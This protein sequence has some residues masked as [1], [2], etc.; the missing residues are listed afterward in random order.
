MRSWR[1]RRRTLTSL[2]LF[3]SLF[4][5]G[6]MAAP[7]LL[8]IGRDCS[9]RTADSGDSVLVVS[10]LL[11]LKH[12]KGSDLSLAR[13]ENALRSWLNTKSDSL[14]VRVLALV[15]QSEHCS[16]SFTS[17]GDVICT[18]ASCQHPTYSLPTISCIMATAAQHARPNEFMMFLNSDVI[19]ASGLSSTLAELRKRFGHDFVMVGRRHDVDDGQKPRRLDVS[20]AL[21]LVQK[22]EESPHS[23]F[24]IDYF[25]FDVK[26]LPNNFPD[27]LIGRWRWDNALLLEFLGKESVTVVDA[28]ESVLAV[29][30]GL[31]RKE[32]DQHKR[33]FGADYNDD[34]VKR[35]YAEAYL[36]GRIDNAPIVVRGVC[37]DCRIQFQKQND[38]LKVLAYRRAHPKTRLLLM[39]TVTAGYANLALNWACW[40]KTSGFDNY[41]FLA[42]DENSL[43]ILRSAGQPTAFVGNQTTL[44]SG[45][46]DYG[47]LQFQIVMTYRTEV[48]QQLLQ[49]GLTVGTADVDIIWT[50]SVPELFNTSCDVIGMPHKKTKMTGG[51]VVVRH[52]E[53]AVTYWTRVLYCQ[54]QNMAFL[55]AHVG[56]RYEAS[57]Y[58]EQE[59][60]NDLRVKF[61]QLNF[62]LLPE[63]LFVDGEAYFTD[64]RP[65][66]TGVVPWAIHNNWIVGIGNKTSRFKDNGLMLWDSEKQSCLRGPEH[67]SLPASIR[68]K[69]TLRIRVLTQSRLSSL[70]RL[71]QSLLDADFGDLKVSLDVSVDAA[72]RADIEQLRARNAT[73]AFLKSFVWKLGSYQ[74]IDQKAHKGIVQQWLSIPAA[75]HE[76]LLILEDDIV[77]SK[78]AFKFITSAVEHFY[79]NDS[80]YDPSLFGIML[81]RQHTILGE[82]KQVRYGRKPAELLPAG[83]VF[84]RYQLVS[85]WA[86]VMIGSVWNSFLSWLD[87]KLTSNVTFIPCVPTLLSNKW[88]LER[89]G[90]LWTPYFIRFAYEMGLYGLYTNHPKGL[91]LITNF[92][93]KGVNFNATNPVDIDSLVTEEADLRVLVKN[94]PP[95][96]DVPLF[97]FHFRLVDVSLALARRSIYMENGIDGC[98]WIGRK[99]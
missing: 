67:P 68:E 58:T 25:L 19:I 11:G 59:C 12:D 88:T 35:R 91:A 56:K 8:G 32:D 40:A 94:T 92:R 48:V 83:T 15:E 34:V 5:M 29:H 1:F 96:N 33:R 95:M 89:P 22:T 66:L 72:D 71:L 50:N 97:D 39:L 55:R 18:V 93:E 76:L 87:G 84:Y 79:V 9:N 36:V 49:M 38:E 27:F 14:S 52:S 60:I 21:R 2:S 75:V 17:L 98:H 61:P 51:F 64:R 16:P 80:N 57:K 3:A 44:D 74:V 69:W 30:Q 37:P 90:Q 77:V 28:S 46:S 62:C 23:P 13:E 63:E 20:E 86:P 7:G 65:Q 99:V 78:Y 70:Q 41:V 85:S 81:Q 54:R 47:S 10:S 43:N 42:V 73:I 4:L 45:A 24:G 53:D 31:P 82:T 6:K 26:S